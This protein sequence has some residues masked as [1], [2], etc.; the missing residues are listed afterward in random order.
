MFDDKLLEKNLSKEM[1]EEKSK[2]K[3]KQRI[4]LIFDYATTK[5]SIINFPYQLVSEI[6]Y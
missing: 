1:S 4:D 6:F 5:F 2:H 3:I